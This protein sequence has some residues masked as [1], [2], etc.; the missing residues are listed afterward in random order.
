MTFHSFFPF[1]TS[2]QRNN[3]GDEFSPRTERPQSAVLLSKY[4]LSKVTLIFYLDEHL[5]GIHSSLSQDNLFRDHC[6]KECSYQK[7]RHLG[8]PQTETL[9]T[10]RVK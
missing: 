5:T 3:S 8:F 1:D 7:H 9:I 10:S 6:H 2:E 4:H